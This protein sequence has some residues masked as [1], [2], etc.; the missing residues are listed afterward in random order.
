MENGVAHILIVDDEETILF[1]IGQYIIALGCTVDTARELEEAQALLSNV[2]YHLVVAD[3]RLSGIHGSEGLDLVSMVRECCPSTRVIVLTAYGSAELQQ[4][5]LR[6]GAD[7]V[8]HKS[9][10]L[11]EVAETAI[12]LL[13]CAA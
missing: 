12:K 9:M 5:A 1:A 13:G 8:L 6:R 4:E 3:L 2:R 10:P 7:A 11:A